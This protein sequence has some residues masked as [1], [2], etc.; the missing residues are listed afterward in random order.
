[1]IF[2]E[3]IKILPSIIIIGL[4][5]LVYIR[6]SKQLNRIINKLSR[7]NMIQFDL[8]GTKMDFVEMW[9]SEFIG[10]RPLNIPYNSY[11]LTKRLEFVIS[12][13]VEINV[14]WIE[15]QQIKI[16]RQVD[17][18]SSLGMNIKVVE[19]SSEALT[20]IKKH[21]KNNKNEHHF[22]LIISDVCRDGNHEEGFDFIKLIVEKYE[23]NIPTIFYTGAYDY[24]K[25]LPPYTFGIAC[26]P[27]ELLW[28]SLDILERNIREEN[29]IS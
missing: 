23:I 18:L 14:L 5:L 4:I 27:H 8:W 22:Q 10:K 9:D 16:K 3:F 28:L 13:N 26:M 29:N 15:D 24:S 1:M 12:Q 21:K 2:I 25:G 11:A 20:L 6:Y 17:R 7:A 19:S